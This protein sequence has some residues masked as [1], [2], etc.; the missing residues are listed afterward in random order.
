MRAL[1]LL[2]VVLAL[3]RAVALLTNGTELF[4]DEAQYWSWSLEPAFGYF[5]KPPLVAWM[6]AAATPICGDGEACVRL[7]A[8]LAN[9]ASAVVLYFIGRR[10]FDHKVG[11][12]CAFTFATLPAVSLFSGVISTDAPL[13]LA[14]SVALLCFIDLL[15]SERPS[16]GSAIGLGV[17]IGL[18]MNAKYAMGYFVLCAALFF[19]AVPAQRAL[20]RRPHLWVALMIALLLLVPN[21]VWNATHGFATL[22]HTAS[23]ANWTGTLFHPVRA[24][25]FFASQLAVFGP[26]LFVA[27]LLVTMGAAKRARRLDETDIL[28]LAFSVPVVL[29]LVVQGLLSGANANWAIT[30]YVSATVLVVSRLVSPARIGWLRASAG[31]HFAI[32]LLVAVGSWQAGNFVLPGGLDP[33]ARVLGSR[34]LAAEVRAEVEAGSYGSVLTTD[35]TSTAALLYYARDMTVPLYVWL[36]GKVPTNHFEMTRPFT[37]QSQMQTLLVSRNEDVARITGQF[38]NVKALGE[39]QIPVGRFSTRRVFLYA[40]SGFLGN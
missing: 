23:N 9:L 26:V 10:L 25:E 34:D 1:G 3:F 40:L 30:A 17:A 13:L 2:I 33:F 37:A 29:I 32:A 14:W 7:P 21:V 20:L 31:V 19:V 24:L 35:R 6:I 15:R 38:S 4:V 39:R 18:G 27:W 8:M 36:D 12:W 16:L 22:S 28:L 5:S 11:I